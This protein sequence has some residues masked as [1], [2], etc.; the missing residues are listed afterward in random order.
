MPENNW[1]R[2]IFTFDY[3]FKKAIIIY[4]HNDK[5]LS[6]I[7]VIFLVFFQSQRILKS[8]RVNM[9]STEW[10]DSLKT[11]RQRQVAIFQI[12]VIISLAIASKMEGDDSCEKFPSPIQSWL[13]R[14]WK[15][16]AKKQ[17]FKPFDFVL[18]IMSFLAMCMVYTSQ[19]SP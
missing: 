10:R 17:L 9:R 13:F 11:L 16:S 5:T 15:F 19:P 7:K 18:L 2:T 14:I 6:Y 4:N 1:K 8:R 3:F 12:A